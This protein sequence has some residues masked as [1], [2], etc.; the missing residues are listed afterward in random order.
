VGYIAL[1]LAPPLLMLVVLAAKFQCLEAATAL[2]H[3]QLARHVAAGEGFV[4]D[5][6]RPLSLV[7]KADLRHHPDLYNA[8]AHPLVL[9]L[10]FQRVS[11]KFSGS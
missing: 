11:E 10:F 8:P 7:F 9:A 3:A 4:T 5:F 6:I 2:D 1:A